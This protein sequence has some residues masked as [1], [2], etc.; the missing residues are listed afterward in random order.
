MTE[1]IN[2]NKQISKKIK[3]FFKKQ[4]IR[5]CLMLTNVS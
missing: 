3:H 1:Y 5:T 2:Y 4:I